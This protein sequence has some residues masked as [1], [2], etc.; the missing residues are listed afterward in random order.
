MRENLTKKGN[1]LIEEIM[2]IVVVDLL[3]RNDPTKI[4]MQI[5]NKIDLDTTIVNLLIRSDLVHQ[6]VR[7]VKRGHITIEV[8]IIVTR[9]TIIMDRKDALISNQDPERN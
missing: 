1:T 4:E 6:D 8:M 3:M 9:A 7:M 5:N 2:Q